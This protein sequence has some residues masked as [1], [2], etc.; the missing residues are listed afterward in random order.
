MHSGSHDECIFAFSPR[1]F[2]PRIKSD[3]NSSQIFSKMYKSDKKYY[4]AF[5]LKPVLSELLSASILA[6]AL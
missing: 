6:R 3:Q 5:H 4:F 1:K 2:N